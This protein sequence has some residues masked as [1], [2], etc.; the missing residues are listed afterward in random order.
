MNIVIASPEVVPYAK[1]GGLGDVVGA[2]PECFSQEGHE[3][4][5]FL[6]RYSS[7]D[8][9]SDEMERYDWD[10]TIQINGKMYPVQF[11]SIKSQQTPL[12]IIFIENEEL[13]DR[14]ALYTDP[15]TGEDYLDN[16]V[17][18][19]FFNK[20]VLKIVK[21]LNFQPHIVH[22]H[23]WQ[24]GLIPA[25]LKL[26]YAD[27]PFFSQTKT[28]LT[29]HNL[30]FQGTFENNRF[31]KIG[32]DT[33]LFYPTSPFEFYGKVNFLKAAIYYSDKITT[34]SETYALEI[35]TEE[36]GAG[37]D[38]VLRER[39]D[40]IHGI[41]NGV[42]YSIWNP[43]R[44]K[45]I[46]FKYIPSNLSG[47]KM[48][49]IELLN[50]SSLPIREAT[51]LIGIISR[52]TDQKGFDL[53]EEVSDEIFDLDIQMVLLG[54]G[55]EKYHRLFQSLEKTYPDKCKVFLKF[56]D[57]L[58]H[59]IEAGSDMFLMPSY[60]EPCGLNQMYSLK[61]GTVPIV[62]KVG[63]LADTVID[64]TKDPERGTGFVFEN[65]SGS[66]MLAAIKRAVDVYSHKRLWTKIMKR[67]MK[68]DNS[69]KHAAEN[70]LTLF[71]ILVRQ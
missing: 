16:D 50:E 51:P 63:G 44:D 69:W 4:K 2:L 18:F 21:E 33:E 59:R 65:Y 17:R 41:V 13:F 45:K 9:F 3:V 5:L 40:D 61:Y 15:A 68:V 1:T 29:I 42:D 28:V 43:S 30:A 10:D 37:L 54:T 27:D 60:Y 31:A 20:A 23:D 11:V 38:G 39:S 71:N 24:A 53:I 48:N 66:E 7:V 64:H 62:R 70:Y 25:Y 32:L 22:V 67:S 34:V 19:I 35:Q 6:P 36:F 55:D 26:S 46:P 49:K 12:E 47:K 14:P 52:L 57:A 56:D 8:R 58:A